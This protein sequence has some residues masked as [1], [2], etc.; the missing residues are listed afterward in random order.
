[1]TEGYTK[2][3]AALHAAQTIPAEILNEILGE[4]S[5]A[6]V[7]AKRRIIEGEANEVYAVAFADGLHVI[8]R[9]SRDADK[10]GDQEQ[11]AIRACGLRGVPVPELL[12][13]W[14]RSLEGQPLNICVQRK[15]EGVLLSNAQLPQNVLH[16]IVVQAGDFLA[17]IHAIPVKGF[18]Y[19][20]GQGEGKFLTLASEIAAFLAMEAEFHALAKRLDLSGRTM[21]RALRWV[22]DGERMIGSVEPCLTH[23]DFQAKHIM[24][25]HGAISG[26]IDFGEV[27]GSEPLSDIVRW[28]YYEA[29]RLPL[30]WLQE[31]Y[32]NKQVFDDTFTQRL[33]IKRIAFSLWVMRW[34]DRRGYAE[35]VAEAR[36]KFLRDLAKLEQRTTP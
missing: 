7:I 10:D 15:L 27:A 18:G 33:H 20:N 17:R 3:L 34:Y 25:A 1:M 23:N 8:A 21:N 28:D 22:V 26:I 16:Q 19:I 12:G 24:V 4:I 14:H 30:A 31:G 13:V 9:L 6:P 35:G 32:T 2:H 11:W 5:P 29:E 36:A